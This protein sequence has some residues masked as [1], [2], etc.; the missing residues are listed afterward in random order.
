MVD[1]LIISGT[2][3]QHNYRKVLIYPMHTHTHTNTAADEKKAGEVVVLPADS[4]RPPKDLLEKLKIYPKAEKVVTSW[5]PKVT[6]CKDEETLRWTLNAVFLR[7]RTRGP[8]KEEID[9]ILIP[10]ALA[11]FKKNPEE[12]QLVLQEFEEHNWIKF[13]SPL[14]ETQFFSELFP[15]ANINILVG[16]GPSNSTADD[17]EASERPRIKKE[18]E[19]KAFL[20]QKNIQKIIALGVGDGIESKEI[21]EKISL[22]H[23]FS[24][25]KIGE[26]NKTRYKNNHRFQLLFNVGSDFPP[27]FLQ[28]GVVTKKQGYAQ[29]VNWA[30]APGKNIQVLH[31]EELEYSASLFSEAEI[32]WMHDMVM[33]NI[34]D[35][36]HG[37]YIHCR[38]GQ[39]RSA[40]VAGAL[41]NHRWLIDE[42]VRKLYPDYPINGNFVKEIVPSLRKN[43]RSFYSN[44][45]QCFASMVLTQKLLARTLDYIKKHENVSANLSNAGFTLFPTSAAPAEATKVS[46][47]EFRA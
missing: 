15:K 31:H 44:A 34:L 43:V 33:A 8:S 5:L 21:V 12:L 26:I 11:Y 16:C 47:I 24:G 35:R 27:Y 20:L 28:E 10:N 39:G 13:T 37:C 23:F 25:A 42:S 46:T 7:S 6:I 38:M 40:V 2:I 41:F 22:T 4:N 1:F 45:I 36:S 9:E 17:D 30:V 29:F 3:W 14:I 18:S 32:D 19:F